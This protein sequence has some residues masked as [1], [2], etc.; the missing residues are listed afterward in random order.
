MFPEC[1][2]DALPDTVQ[3]RSGFD[4]RQFVEVA[5]LGSPVAMNFVWVGNGDVKST[6]SDT[7]VSRTSLVSA[8]CG[9]ETRVGFGW[10]MGKWRD[11]RGQVEL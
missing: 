4:I 1:F 3:A 2:R 6:E 8:P 5:G 11:D 10:G 9:I 7:V